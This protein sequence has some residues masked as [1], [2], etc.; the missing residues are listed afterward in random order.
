M[1]RLR[2]RSREAGSN[3]VGAVVRGPDWRR[4]AT[5]QHKPQ[6]GT[7]GL[8]NTGFMQLLCTQRAAPQHSRLLCGTPVVPHL[9]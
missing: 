3:T 4:Y 2:L 9:L 8:H 5:S 7:T 1:V 6:Y